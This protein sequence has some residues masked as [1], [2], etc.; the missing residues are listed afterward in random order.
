MDAIDI[1]I[2]PDGTVRFI[3]S[4]EA[5]EV[6]AGEPQETTRAS[7]VE[8]WRYGG[9]YADMSPSGGPR[10][11]LPDYVIDSLNQVIGRPGGFATRQEA[12]DAELAWLRK[13]R[14]L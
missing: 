10:M 5:A 7:H 11:L 12:L 3:Y 4:D 9:W 13:E 14:G 8:P 1:V 6:F 2:D